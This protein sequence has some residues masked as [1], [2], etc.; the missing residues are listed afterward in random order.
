[1][2]QF[3]DVHV[4]ESTAFKAKAKTNKFCSEAI[5]F[6]KHNH[7]VFSLCLKL[8]LNV[9]DTGA[10]STHTFPVHR[11]VTF[12]LPVHSNKTA[13]YILHFIEDGVRLRTEHVR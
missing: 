4:L 8:A 5:Q 11:I 1:M 3:L 12:T 13:V 2:S 6:K 7:N 9:D 10:R